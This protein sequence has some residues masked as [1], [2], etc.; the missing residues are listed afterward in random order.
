MFSKM[1][2]PDSVEQG[3]T[4][5]LTFTINNDANS[6]AATGLNFTDDMTAFGLVLTS[7]AP[8][9]GCGGSLTADPDTS[10]V[11]FSGGTVAAGTTCE[12]TVTLRA[13]TAGSHDNVS[14]TLFSNLPTQPPAEDTLAVSPA[15]VPTLSKT[16]SNTDVEEGEVITMTLDFVNPNGF[17]DAE[18]VDL[19]DVMTGNLEVVN[20]DASGSAGCVGTVAGAIGDQTVS[21]TGTVPATAT[22]TI[23]VDLIVLAAADFTNTATMTSSLGNASAD[24]PVTVT[25]AVTPTLSKTLSKT[26]VE[27]GEPITMTLEIANPNGFR[28]AESVVLTDDMTGTLV[29]STAATGTPGCDGTVAG[30]VGAET[31][32]FTGTVAATET[33]TITVGLVVTARADF[34]N[35]ASMTSSLGNASTDVPVTVTP[36]PPLT[37]TMDFLPDTVEVSQASTLRYTIENTSFVPATA[38][39]LLDN[40]PANLRIARPVTTSNTCTGGIVGAVEGGGTISYD[41]GALA[42]LSTCTVSVDVQS[43]VADTYPNDTETQT[44]SLGDSAAASATLTV[45]AASTGSITIVQETDTDGDFVFS[46]AEPALNFTISTSRGR[47]ARGPIDLPVGSYTITQ[48]PPAGIGT[49]AI[50]CDDGDS[51]GDPAARTITLNLSGLEAVTC[52][53]SSVGTLQKTVD[54]INRFLTKRAD[55]ILSSE[56]RPGRRFDRLKRGYGNAT[57]LSWSPG[58]LKAFLPFTADF[59]HGSNDYRFSTSMLQVRQAAAS[60]ALAHGS[61][62]DAIYVDNYRFDAWFEAQFKKFDS[63]AQGD[64]HFAVAYFGADYLVT[65]DM[66]VGV[67]L[68]IDDMEDL[69][70]ALNTS[71][72]GT[73]WMVGPYMTARLAPNLYFDGRVAAGRSTNEVSPFNTYVDEF[74]TDRWLAMASITGDFQQGPWTIR[75]TASLS[76]FEETQDSLRRRHRG[77][78]PKP[79]RA[80]GPAEDRADLHRQVRDQRRDATGALFRR[81]RDLQH[82]RHTRRDGHQSCHASHRR[83]ARAAAGRSR[84]HDRSRHADQLWRHL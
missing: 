76:Y 14:S 22:C 48:N 29:V 57:Q 83:L 43:G 60:V 23:T 66:L 17:L 58:D 75:P 27:E 18:T 55:L 10:V 16:L 33:C 45:E 52:T 56:P 15:Q 65:P 8:V 36:A 26:A 6:I 68:Q 11:S 82:R 19:Q 69:S 38:I 42:A 3:Q 4:T 41:G 81:R 71:A 13:D 5:E 80:P 37:F 84:R 32:S 46:S 73:G 77:D 1:F 31:V 24:V 35:T 70:A 67:I 21:F 50:S 39:S 54:T 25:A 2:A 30:A 51:T 20:A 53:V 47:G 61:T 62:K 79:D 78:D 28:A 63:G 49:T 74:K 59:A 44:S 34:T 12:I 7:A 9:N 72:R 64:G 40:L